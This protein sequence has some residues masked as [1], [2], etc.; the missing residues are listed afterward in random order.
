MLTR[1]R[2]SGFKNLVGLDLHFGPF[3]CIAGVN[4][5]GKSN[6]FDAVRLLGD[7]AGRSLVEAAQSV[8][9]AAGRAADVDGLFYRAGADRGAAMSFAVEMIVPGEATDDL[10]QT[11][12]PSISFLDYRLELARRPDAAAS[13]LGPLEIVKEELGHINLGE[14][15]KH[16]PFPHRAATWRKSAVAGSRRVP[17]ISTE[18]DGGR[19]VVTL[20]QDGGGGGPRSVPAQ[21]LPRTVL[22]AADA[23]SSPTALLARRE[24][25]SWRLLQLEPA[26]LREPDAFG[27][28][29]SLAGNGAHLA[30]TLNRLAGSPPPLLAGPG[31]PRPTAAQV[32]GQVAARLAELV[33]DVREVRVDADEKRELLT[34]MVAGGDGAA[35]PA[36]A[37]ADGA[38][39]A[40]ALTV[41][42]IDPQAGGLLCIEDP[43]DGLHPARL[44]ALLRLLQSIPTDVEAA[45]GTA[46]PM[47]QVIVN[48]HSPALVSGVPDA[49]LLVAEPRAA[50]SDGRSARS[51]AFRCLAGTWRERMAAGTEGLQ[52]LSRAEMLDQMHLF[53]RP[54]PAKRARRAGGRE[55]PQALLPYS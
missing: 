23:G 46:N 15:H 28:P 9:A 8:R 27:A 53:Q 24:M 31:S 25:E 21:S 12:V 50:A 40:L 20:H 5:A 52:A 19:R 36:R 35:H 34:L 17:F 26:S 51:V 13:R 6:L 16:L 2:V 14:A 7:L 45:V 38:L 47:R 48:T 54:G 10:G 43:E 49:A 29:G 18:G 30:A 1:L 11:A 39:R 42:A 41:L 55:G 32:Y 44:P 37:L 22:S 3:T 33:E 4:G